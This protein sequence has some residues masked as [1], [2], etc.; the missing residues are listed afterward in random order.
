MTCR[1]AVIE[2]IF[3]WAAP[4][5]WLNHDTKAVSLTSWGS[6]SFTFMA[7]V[8][9]MALPA[10]NVCMNTDVFI[11]DDSRLHSAC[12]LSTLNVLLSLERKLTFVFF[13]LARHSPSKPGLCS[14]FV[15]QFSPSR[16]EQVSFGLL[17]YRKRTQNVCI[18]SA[19]LYIFLYKAKILSLFFKYFR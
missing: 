6:A 7:M 18:C 8:S 10:Q 14:C 12:Q 17:A 11:D 1:H 13:L 15:R 19:K 2:Q 3:S 9:R 5:P 4:H 16:S